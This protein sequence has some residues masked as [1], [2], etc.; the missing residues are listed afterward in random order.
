V[1]TWLGLSALAFAPF[2][3]VLLWAVAVRRLAPE[4][5]LAASRLEPADLV[6]VWSWLRAARA[7]GPEGDDARRR[8]LLELGAVAIAAWAFFSV[9]PPWVWPSCALGWL[10]LAAG[11]IDLRERIL[12]DEI[13]AAIAVFGLLAAVP[14]GQGEVIGRAIGAAVGF[15]ALAAFALGYARLRGREGLGLGDAKLLGALGAWVGWQGLASVLVIAAGAG[16]ASVLTGAALHRRAPRSDEAL[17]FGPYLALG[18]WLV[19]LY[20]PLAFAGLP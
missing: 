16:V 14:L 4:P 15:A 3:G 9:A 8:A 5:G 7:E 19:W 1:T 12:P 17:A 20:G 10:L 2:A 11:V 13:N 6:P 18:G